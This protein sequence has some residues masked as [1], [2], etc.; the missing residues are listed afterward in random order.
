MST[1][2]LSSIRSSES[3]MRHETTEKEHDIAHEVLLVAI[4]THIAKSEGSNQ[5]LV[6]LGQSVEAIIGKSH[7]NSARIAL[8][9]I[10]E[11]K[12]NFKK[13]QSDS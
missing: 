12:E 7:P 4:L 3:S 11:A 5:G 2:N 13:P 6:A 1:F 8:D 9:L 10:N